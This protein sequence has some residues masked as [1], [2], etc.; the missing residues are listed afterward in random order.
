MSLLRVNEPS[1]KCH[2]F[3]RI[4]LLIFFG[5]YLG[6]AALTFL[7]L[8][9]GSESDRRENRI[10]AAT[11]GVITGPFTGAIARHGQ[12]CCWQ[13]SLALAPYCAGVF[14]LGLLFQIIPLP[15]PRLERTLRLAL[16]CLGL[17]GWFGG[18]LLS[19]AHALS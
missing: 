9:A 14:A 12:T 3:R 2:H 6:F 10:L 8:N 15:F 7:V 4:H 13:F 17:L 5:C 16:W 11:T 19:F 1:A 18:V